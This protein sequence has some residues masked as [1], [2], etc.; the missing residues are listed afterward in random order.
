MSRPSPTPWPMPW[1]L[2]IASAI[3]M[4]AATSTGSTRAPFL[5][6]MA[7]DLEVSLPAIAN[8]FGV[9]ATTW[10]ISS[11]LV[12][13]ASDRIGRRV[14]L[15]ASPALLALTMVAASQASSYGMLIVFFI[16]AAMCCGAF[17]SSAMAEVSLR[18]QNTHQ[19]RALGYV[20]SGQSL[21]LLIGVPVSAW[22][23]AKIGWRGTHMALA[24]LAVFAVLCMF[25]ALRW[26]SSH[27]RANS[28]VNKPKNQTTIKQAMTGPVIRLFIALGIERLCFGLAAFYYASYLRTTYNLPVQAVAIPLAIFAVG[29]ILGTMIGGQLADRFAYR[30]V[31]FSVPIVVAGFIA[32]PWFLWPAVLNVTIGFGFM[33]AFFNALGRPS[34]LA[35]MAD[36]PDDVRGVIM[37]LNSSVASMGWLT[38]ALLGGWLYA[39]IGFGAFGVVM[40]I[41]SILA[42][43]VVIPDSR[44]R[45]RLATD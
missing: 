26:A 40:A 1:P 3:G 21:T 39:F 44:I 23:G 31:S 4:F 11:Y 34:L 24:G 32:L 29:N 2:V 20:M 28:Q 30:R 5:T 36:V 17:T 42:A 16:A 35:A 25:V 14:F 7:A 9:T 38:A 6:D 33:F 10:G 27:T 12:G 41:A 8:L 43:T 13:Y 22:I 18:T 45:A 37:G 15:L 19:G